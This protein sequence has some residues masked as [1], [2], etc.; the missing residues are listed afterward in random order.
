MSLDIVIPSHHDEQAAKK[1]LS[2]LMVI[3]APFGAQ[4]PAGIRNWSGITVYSTDSYA[5]G[6]RIKARVPTG[7]NSLGPC[8]E[9]WFDSLGGECSRHYELPDKSVMEAVGDW[10]AGVKSFANEVAQYYGRLIR[11]LEQHREDCIELALRLVDQPSA[12][13]P[14]DV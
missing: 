10:N 1:L 3:T 5:S 2:A 13:K 12:S 9:Y 4:E 6:T 8:V 11:S 14:T 7:A